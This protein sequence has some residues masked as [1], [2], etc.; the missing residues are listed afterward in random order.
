[1]KLKK[2]LRGIYVLDTR[3]TKGRGLSSF[4][5][6]L[7]QKTTCSLRVA[8]QVWRILSLQLISRQKTSCYLCVAQKASSLDPKNQRL[9]RVAR[10]KPRFGKFDFSINRVYF[11]FI[12]HSFTN[13]RTE[14]IRND[15][16]KFLGLYSFFSSFNF[17]EWFT[18][19]RKFLW[20]LW[21]AKYPNSRDVA[22]GWMKLV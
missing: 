13:F 11:S 10:L 5:L 1:M 7:K 19:I 21:V 22:T 2:C 4:E 9:L 6:I 14:S 20:W 3:C 17:L 8:Q 18:Y 15:T 16:L 12:G